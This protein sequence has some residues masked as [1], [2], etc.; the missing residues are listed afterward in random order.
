MLFFCIIS[1]IKLLG[2]SIHPLLLTTV[3]FFVK[4]TIFSPASTLNPSF[5]LGESGESI[6]GRLSVVSMVN[7]SRP[8]WGGPLHPGTLIRED[9]RRFLELQRRKL[10]DELQGWA[11]AELVEKILCRDQNGGLS[12]GAGHFAHG[13]PL[14][15][16]KIAG[17]MM[18]NGYG[19][20][21]IDTFLVG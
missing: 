2:A 6:L 7:P 9:R 13:N 14:G 3:F 18:I 5:L 19:S 20:I 16:I 15:N 10:K 8:P 17:I 11:K 1:P 21:P 4:F 12:S